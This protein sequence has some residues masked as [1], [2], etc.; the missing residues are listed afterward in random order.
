MR[1]SILPTSI[2]NNECELCRN[3]Q[4][5]HDYNKISCTCVEKFIVYNVS[6]LLFAAK[7]SENDCDPFITFC[8]D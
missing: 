3:L 2:N 1:N 6:V 5:R 7:L 4:K 8:F